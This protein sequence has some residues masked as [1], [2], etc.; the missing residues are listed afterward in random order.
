MYNKWL[1]NVLN[2]QGNVF[3]QYLPHTRVANGLL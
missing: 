2:K 1:V 3:R